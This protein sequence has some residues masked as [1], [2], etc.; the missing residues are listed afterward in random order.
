MRNASEEGRHLE[1]LWIPLWDTFSAWL[2]TSPQGWSA[3]VAII[4]L[5]WT[6]TAQTVAWRRDRYSRG[7]DSLS[8]LDERFESPDFRAVRRKASA[9]LLTPKADNVE[10]IQAVRTV[11]NLFETIGFL[12][13]TKMVTVEIVWHYFGTWLLP[14]CV[15]SKKYI[16]RTQE[17]DPQV[18][19]EL[20]GIYRAVLRYDK[21]RHPKGKPYAVTS[22]DGV[23]RLLEAEATL[24]LIAEPSTVAMSS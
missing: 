19:S 5:I 12:Y 22:D 20:R 3:V 4:A 1:S 8:D 15:A 6:M 16:E 7:L 2:P 9:Y 21:R 11:L 17:D 10:G 14:Y 24:S 23:A 18:Y 13:R